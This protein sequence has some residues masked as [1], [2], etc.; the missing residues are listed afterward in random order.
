[1]RV[2]NVC[3]F[4]WLMGV[5]MAL[6]LAAQ[7][8]AHASRKSMSNKIVVR[9]VKLFAIGLFLNGGYDLGNWRVPGVLQVR[10]RGC[11]DVMDMRCT[12]AARCSVFDMLSCRRFVVRG[13]AHR[14]TR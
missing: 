10:R 3:R 6:S 2:V 1:M 8:K 11:V 9:S 14:A 7:H 4:M 12:T 5:S 13:R